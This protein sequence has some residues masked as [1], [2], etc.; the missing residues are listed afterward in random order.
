M[1]LRT[2]HD[3]PVYVRLRET[4]ADAIVAGRYRDGDPLPSVRAL[5][6]EEQANP[7]TVAKAY[8]GFQDE[9]LIVV[10]RGVGMFVA[11][12]AR[13][14]LSESERTRFLK[15][16]WPEIR[17]RMDRLGIDPVSLLDRERA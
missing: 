2:S 15:E 5:A 12:G 9:G 17:A 3:K 1:T 6:A 16:E 4:I 13:A 10:K 14:R 11:P 7:L 8:Q